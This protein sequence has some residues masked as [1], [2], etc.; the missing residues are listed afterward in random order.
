LTRR[1]RKGERNAIKRPSGRKKRKGE[2]LLALARLKKKKRKES[3]G[4]GGIF[5]SARGG[6]GRRGN[7]SEYLKR[8]KRI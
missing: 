6:G 3:S 7:L 1:E 5:H 4:A 8:G 2:G